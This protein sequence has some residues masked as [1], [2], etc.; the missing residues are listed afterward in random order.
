[1]SHGPMDKIVLHQHILQRRRPQYHIP[2]PS[3][4]A[5][6]RIDRRAPFVDEPGLGLV[7]VGV[8]S[9]CF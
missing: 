9:F 3:P 7:L 8:M 4:K 1:M 5:V 6:V 2:P